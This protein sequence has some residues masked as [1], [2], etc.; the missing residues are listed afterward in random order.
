MAFEPVRKKASFAFT[1]TLM[2]SP[3]FGCGDG[4]VIDIVKRDHIRLP[5]RGRRDTAFGLVGLRSG[6]IGVSFLARMLA[7]L[8]WSAMYTPWLASSVSG[9]LLDR[10]ALGCGRSKLVFKKSKSLPH[11]PCYKDM[12]RL[13]KSAFLPRIALSS[14][15]YDARSDERQ[16]T[17]LCIA[18]T[19]SRRG[20]YR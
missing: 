1:R 20:G 3:A 19:Q 14:G 5:W 9:P 6:L 2:S 15:V 17:M 4:V 10:R 12:G 13:L 16:R 18:W 7:I 8:R 11:A